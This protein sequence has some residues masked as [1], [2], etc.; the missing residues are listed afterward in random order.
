MLF[1]AAGNLVAGP[2]LISD[3]LPTDLSRPLTA[4]Y[5]EGSYVIPFLAYE[6]VEVDRP[7]CPECGVEQ[8]PTCVIEDYHVYLVRLSAHTGELS[9]AVCLDCRSDVGVHVPLVASAADGVYMAWGTMLA[10]VTATTTPAEPEW[11]E[12]VFPESQ[13]GF[14]SR[15]LHEIAAWPGEA[16]VVGR[17]DSFEPGFTVRAFVARV[18][19][20]Q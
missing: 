20:P 19:W 1:D 18:R 15:E 17:Y 13:G 16:M 12:L 2:L 4:G 9:S 14:V 5:H 11:F 6:T 10:R 3:Q 7:C 8:P